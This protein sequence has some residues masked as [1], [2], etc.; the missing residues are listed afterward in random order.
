MQD[1]EPFYAWRDLY[2]A[3]ED[4]LSPFFGREYSEFVYSNTIYNY[5]IHPQWDEFGSGTLY[6]KV[7]YSD[8]DAGYAIIELIG[9]W[10]DAI[11]NDIMLLKRDVIDAM[12]STGI[13]KFILIGENVLNFHGSDDCYYQEWFDDVEDGWIA[14]I[15]FRDHVLSE[16]SKFN[17]DYYLVFGGELDNLKWRSFNPLQLFTKVEQIVRHRLA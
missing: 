6:L 17:I 2:V 13:N 5:Y 9:E 4:E 1:I 14:A 10:N 11:N 8:Y 12:S 7:L 16:L 15:N 3:A